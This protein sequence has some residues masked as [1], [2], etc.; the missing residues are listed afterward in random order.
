MIKDREQRRMTVNTS[1]DYLTEED[2]NGCRS[3]DVKWLVN[4]NL[5]EQLKNI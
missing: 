1:N 2:M 4:K 5:L 3:D